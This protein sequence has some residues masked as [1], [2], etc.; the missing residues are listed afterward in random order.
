MV[1]R[2]SYERIEAGEGLISSATGFVQ[3]H[4]TTIR[5]LLS[6]PKKNFRFFSIFF[7]FSLFPFFPFPGGPGSGSGG[8][9]LL[10]CPRRRRDD[11]PPERALAERG[12]TKVGSDR[13][14]R[15]R[16]MFVMTMMAMM[17]MTMMGSNV[18]GLNSP[19]HNVGCRRPSRERNIADSGSYSSIVVLVVR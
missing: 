7:P 8:R 18:L 9:F 19:I 16:K 13:S 11:Q 6:R 1:R 12:C 5:V 17:M 4:C 10:P 3:D 14:P 2:G 15:K